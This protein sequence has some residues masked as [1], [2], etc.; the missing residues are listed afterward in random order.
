[1]THAQKLE[2]IRQK[3]AQAQYPTADEQIWDALARHNTFRLADVLL[4]IAEPLETADVAVIAGFAHFDQGISDGWVWDL[5]RDDLSTQPEETI[6][7]I[8]ELFAN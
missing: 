1:V 8:V 7:F 5:R 6:N 4:A 3:C 2:L